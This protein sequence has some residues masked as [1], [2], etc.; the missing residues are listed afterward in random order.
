METRCLSQTAL[1]KQEQLPNV[2]LQPIRK[3][4]PTPGKA[5]QGEKWRGI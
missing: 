3:A 4:Q 1:L 5:A 2:E